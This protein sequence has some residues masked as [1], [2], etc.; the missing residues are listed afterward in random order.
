MFK[1]ELI[2]IIN[3]KE[4]ETKLQIMASFKSNFFELFMR[5]CTIRSSSKLLHV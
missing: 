3:E 5:W 2:N 4:N 1:T